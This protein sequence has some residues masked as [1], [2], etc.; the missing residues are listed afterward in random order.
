[1]VILCVL[2]SAANRPLHGIFNTEH[3]H[4]LGRLMPGFSCFWMYIWFCQYMLIWYAN[5]PEETSYF[6][7]RTHGAWGPIVVT[8]IALNW[9]VPFFVLL[10]RPCKRSDSV[11]LKIAVV[12]LVGRWVDLYVMVFPPTTGDVPVF[13]LPELAGIACICSLGPLLFTRAF[14]S[15]EPVPKNEPFLEESLSYHS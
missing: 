10:P 15:G 1:M 3:L 5:I 8:S 6:I 4:D 13:G 11:M 7:T 9:L 14:A 2:L 12:V